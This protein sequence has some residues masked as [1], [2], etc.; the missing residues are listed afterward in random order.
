[1]IGAGHILEMIKRAESNMA[2]CKKKSLFKKDREYLRTTKS[3]K[4][5]FKKATEEEMADL[6]RRIKI[7]R[8]KENI[9]SIIVFIIASLVT[10]ILVLI[11]VKVAPG[12][13]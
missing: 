11:F 13:M 9:K 4:L 3:K 7:N 6:R 10:L 5:T 2:L 8:K 12:F 1:M